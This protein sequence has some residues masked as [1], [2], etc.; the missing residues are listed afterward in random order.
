MKILGEPMRNMFRAIKRI[1]EEHDDVQVVYPVHM[2]P[3][4][5]EVADEILGR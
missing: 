3:A 2:N 5:R 1:V 4:V